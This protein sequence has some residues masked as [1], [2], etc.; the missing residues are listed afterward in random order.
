MVPW[1]R[2][3]RWPTCAKDVDQGCWHLLHVLLSQEC[4][5]SWIKVGWCLYDSCCVQVCLCFA[6]FFSPEINQICPWQSLNM[7]IH[8]DYKRMHA[9][10]LPACR[11]TLLQASKASHFHAAP[12]DVKATSSWLQTKKMQANV[13]FAN[14]SGMLGRVIA[15]EYKFSKILRWP[16]VHPQPSLTTLCSN[17]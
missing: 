9:P 1:D 6:L 3:A 14:K 15:L 8:V 2:V 4:T 16:A 10:T 12:T 5:K 13:I 17:S 11:R 7:F